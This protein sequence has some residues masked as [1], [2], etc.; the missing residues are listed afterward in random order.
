MTPKQST[1]PKQHTDLNWAHTFELPIG[2]MS[3]NLKKILLDGKRPDRKSH[4]EL[5]KMTEQNM[6]NVCQKPLKR[7]TNSVPRRLVT[8]FHSLIDTNLENDTILGI[9]FE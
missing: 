6:V 8:K 2:A 3:P 1:T 4:R 9:G 7:Y 5:V